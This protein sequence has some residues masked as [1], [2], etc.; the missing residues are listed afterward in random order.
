MNYVDG[1]PE[2]DNTHPVLAQLYSEIATLK[3]ANESLTQSL[4]LAN[5]LKNNYYTKWNDIQINLKDALTNALDDYD[6]ETVI[7]I[8][9]QT[10]IDLTVRKTAQVNLTFTLEFDV[11]AGEDD[12]D[13]EWDIDFEPTHPW[14]VD[15]S[16]DTIYANYT[17]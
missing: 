14:L 8:A 13:L 4:E 15:Y 5:T 2:M 6:K 7:Y 9:E 11:P 1:L 16:S 12:P 3:Q 10:G 17:D